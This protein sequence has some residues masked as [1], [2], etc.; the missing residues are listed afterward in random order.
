M[1]ITIWNSRIST[2]FITRPDPSFFRVASKRGLVYDH[3]PMFLGSSCT[4]WRLALGYFSISA[5]TRSI[6]NGE[7]CRAATVAQHT[8]EHHFRQWNLV[9][10][11][12]S[13]HFSIQASS[14][15]C[16]LA[17]NQIT[18]N[19]EALRKCKLLLQNIIIN[20]SSQVSGAILW[21]HVGIC[22]PLLVMLYFI[23][24]KKFPDSD[25][26]DCKIQSTASC[27]RADLF[28]R[29]HPQLFEKS[30]WCASQQTHQD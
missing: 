28:G 7:I 18:I 15:T 8:V 11:T 21:S 2:N 16:L 17:Y 4:Q 9:I 26:G 13:T 29:F 20:T 27:P 6:G 24:S 14:W 19:Q 10:I 3:A 5:L 1:T 25:P 23:T 22:T 30:L 12:H